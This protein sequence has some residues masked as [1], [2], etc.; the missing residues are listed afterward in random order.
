M[1]FEPHR[2][3]QSSATAI[4]AFALMAFAAVTF[5]QVI[6]AEDTPSL[7]EPHSE[8]HSVDAGAEPVKRIERDRP[9][10]KAQRVYMDR[11]VAQPMSHLAASWL[12][13]PE[14]EQEENASK[15]FEK[16]GIKQGMAVCDLGCGNGFWTF[17]MAKAVGPKGR[18]IAVDIQR[19]MLQKLK[20][21]GNRLKLENIEPILGKVNDPRLP[22]NQVDLL[23]M[24]DVYHEFSHPESMLW[25]IRRSLTDEGV[26]A[27]LEYRA[28]DP[29]VPIKPLHKMTK[30]QIMKEYEKNGLKLVR[31]YNRL[32][33]QHLMFFARDDSPLKEISP[34]P[35]QQVL[36][37][38]KSSKTAPISP[39]VD[40]E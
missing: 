30:D 32:P 5:P 13:R 3:L 25:S 21:R 19:E 16:L 37:D 26:V 6:R 27:L 11:I 12:V 38:L 7:V 10:E 8:P 22:A 2:R 34:V 35:T 23:L 1:R 29:T 28:E 39:V 24:V 18:V 14:R 40:Q 20:A 4:L 31:E 15:S 9:R 36:D 17:P 33:W